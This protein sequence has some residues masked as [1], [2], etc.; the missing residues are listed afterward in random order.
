MQ[1]AYNAYDLLT[2]VRITKTSIVQHDPMCYNDSRI[3]LQDA[4]GLCNG[5]MDKAE[6]IPGL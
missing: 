6:T 5:H 1:N 4:S 2:L 3:F